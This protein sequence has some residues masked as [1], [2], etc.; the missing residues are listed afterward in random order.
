MT[1]L[2]VSYI[3]V[4]PELITTLSI[5]D[6]L[7]LDLLPLR[8]DSR[9]FDLDQLHLRTCVPQDSAH[10][11]L[12]AVQPLREVLVD[13]LAVVGLRE[14]HCSSVGNGQLV[15]NCRRFVAKNER[16]ITDRSATMHER[17][18]SECADSRVCASDL[19]QNRLEPRE[20]VVTVMPLL[21]DCESVLPRLD[22][23]V[24]I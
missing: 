10:F 20:S 6:N 24:S 22:M 8:D 17:Y 14:C 2:F 3:D 23:S 4:A 1:H 12:E 9:N 11:D 7:F 19:L 21:T 18:A 16:L 13:L 15:D 5:S